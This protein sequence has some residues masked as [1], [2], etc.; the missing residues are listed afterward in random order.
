MNTITR[1]I[2]DELNELKKENFTKSEIIEIISKLNKDKILPKVESNGIFILPENNLVK[3]N[4]TEYKLPKKVFELLYYFII[5][6]NT[7]ITRQNILRDVWGESIYVG[8]RTVDVH[9]RKIRSM[10]P[11]NCIKTYKGVGYMWVD[12]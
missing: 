5:N 7:N 9:I 11:I 3:Y 10:I 2:I 12:K 8:D 4:G 1:N 6:K